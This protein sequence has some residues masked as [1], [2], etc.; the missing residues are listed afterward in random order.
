[1]NSLVNLDEYTLP[2][3]PAKYTDELLPVFVTMLQG[4]S[5]ILDPFG[6]TG[7]IFEIEPLLRGAKIES[8]EIEPEW[9]AYHPRTTLGSALALP[10]PDDTFDAI[11]TS[12][13]YGNRMADHH[14]ATDDSRRNTYTHAIGHKLHKQNSGQLQWGKAYKDFHERAWIEARR[15]LV[16]QSKFVLNIKD[17]IRNGKRQHVTDWHIKC[18][19]LL[20]F[21]LI[22]H[23]RVDCPGLR[24]GANSDARIDYESVILFELKKG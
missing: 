1:M 15:V 18:L 13:T 4:S 2:R 17:H 23:H 11:C 3:H 5:Y 12:P 20:G 22:W 14:D 8:V 6:G 21:T 7:K 10:W 19:K 9:A 24:H 16:H